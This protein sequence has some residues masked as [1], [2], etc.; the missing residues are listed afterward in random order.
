MNTKKVTVTNSDKYQDKGIFSYGFNY[1]KYHE[2]VLN[3]LK[4]E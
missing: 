2:S 1:V 3:F 4:K